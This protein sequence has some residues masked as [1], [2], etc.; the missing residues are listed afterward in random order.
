MI[1]RGAILLARITSITAV[2]RNVSFDLWS[3]VVKSGVLAISMK[4][5]ALAPGALSFARRRKRGAVRRL[6]ALGRFGPNSAYVARPLV[7]A[8]RTSGGIDSKESSGIFGHG[9]TAFAGRAHD[10]A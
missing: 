2:H 10:Y 8:T 7:G 6:P 1:H 9:G 5:G 4:S 3:R